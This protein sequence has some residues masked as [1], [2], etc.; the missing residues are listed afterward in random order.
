[1]T[2]DIRQ[3]QGGLNVKDMLLL[4]MI[5]SSG[6][7]CYRSTRCSPISVPLTGA[8]A[9]DI[10][11]AWD[12]YGIDSRIILHLMPNA[13][14]RMVEPPN[15]YAPNGLVHSFLWNLV[16]AGLEFD[17]GDG[18]QS[19]PKAVKLTETILTLSD[20]YL[21]DGLADGGAGNTYDGQKYTRSSCIGFGF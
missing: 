14:A 17:Y 16:D 9:T 3:P 21:A 2:N 18:R 8:L 10:L 13:V 6:T 19:W 1:M 12:G 4:V 5:A 20:V 7:A 11:G 15:Q